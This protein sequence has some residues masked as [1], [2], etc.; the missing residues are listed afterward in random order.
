[1]GCWKIRAM[2]VAIL[3][4]NEG[5]CEPDWSNTD[6]GCVARRGRQ[7]TH[8]SSVATY[9]SSNSLSSIGTTALSQASHSLDPVNS[10]L[11]NASK[12]RP[13]VSEDAGIFNLAKDNPSSP[14]FFVL[15]F[16]IDITFDIATSPRNLDLGSYGPRATGP[17]LVEDQ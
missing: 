10:M 8:A 16:I 15:L 11:V 17:D 3:A 9:I 2:T 13:S 4:A 14:I 1:M 12:R 6:Q 7:N 5:V